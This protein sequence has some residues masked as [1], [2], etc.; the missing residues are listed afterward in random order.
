MSEA[1][2]LEGI[3]AWIGTNPDLSADAQ[4]KILLIA[5]EDECRGGSDAES[6]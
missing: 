6:R 2:S 5:L 3:K 1:L 4:D